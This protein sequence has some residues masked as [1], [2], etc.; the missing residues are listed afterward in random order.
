M[1]PLSRFAA[2]FFA[3]LA[4]VSCHAAASTEA[5]QTGASTACYFA[6][7]PPA[8]GGQL[9]YY[10]SRVPG[11][12]AAPTSALI[13]LHGHSR[14]ANK[15]FD[16]ALLAVRRAGRDADTLVIAPV[17]Q[18]EAARAANCRTAGVP[19]AQPGDLLW[20]CSS[21]LEGAASANGSRFGSFAALDALVAELVRQWPSLRSVTIAGFS[22]GAQMVQ[23]SIGF[24]A[25]PPAGVTLRYVVADP[26]SWLYFDAFRPH[27]VDAANCPAVNRWKYGTESLPAHFTRDAAQARAHYAAAEIHYLEGE[28]DSDAAKGT[29][30]RVL[31]TSCAANAQGP[32]RLQRGQ[33]YLTYDR[34]LLAPAHRRELVVVPGCAHD[35]ACVFP[36]PAASAAL[37][38]APR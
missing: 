22:A 25:A 1:K 11:A 36:S 33:A 30:Y 37:L 29:A 31:D 14:D 9:H 4:T 7:E 28:L 16:A 24:A 3:F 23:H 19:A 27:P 21:W 38:G 2:I 35:V 20:T 12:S 13:A 34:A 32:F 10:A 18:V 5:C 8:A 6:F 15:T 17:F 26:G